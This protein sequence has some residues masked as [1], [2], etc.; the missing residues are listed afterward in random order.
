LAANDLARRGRAIEAGWVVLTGG[1]TDAVFAPPGCTV[2]VKFS[3]LGAGVIEGG[4]DPPP[5][6]GPSY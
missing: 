6:L 3:S 4:E 1:I 5:E 2:E